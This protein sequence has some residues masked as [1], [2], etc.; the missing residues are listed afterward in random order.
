MYQSHV[1]RYTEELFGKENVF[2]AGTVSGLQ[3][4]TA[5]G[6]VK[7]Y[8]EERGKT[9]NR[10]EE[11]RLVMGCTGVKRTTGQHPGGRRQGRSAD[12]PL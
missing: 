5:Y 7:K 11:N 6:Y 9:V 10:A 4:K 3:D 12:D 1:H 8:L 2:K